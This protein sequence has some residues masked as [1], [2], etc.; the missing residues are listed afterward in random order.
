M[1]R[2]SLYARGLDLYIAAGRLGPLVWLTIVLA[3]GA[4]VA[5][6]WLLPDLRA[7]RVALADR[8]QAMRHPATAPMAPSVVHVSTAAVRLGDF[9]RVLGDAG[10]QEELIRAMFANARQS[11]L[12]LAEGDYV[13]APDKSGMYQTLEVSQPVHGS[14]RQVRAYCER[15]LSAMPFAALDALQFKREGVAAA[16]GEARIQWTLYLRAA[17][18]VDPTLRGRP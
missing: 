4:A 14:Y 16:T 3:L 15:T 18:P 5:Q 1:S 6:A 11:E 12:E 13:G 2:P 9:E 7:Q 8:L 17:H 10:H